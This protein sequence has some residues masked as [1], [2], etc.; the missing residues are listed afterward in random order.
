MCQLEIVPKVKA[1]MSTKGV[2]EKMEVITTI[3]HAD[4]KR[5]GELASIP[6]TD[7]AF[8]MSFEGSSGG[9]VSYVR[10]KDTT[11]NTTIGSTV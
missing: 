11:D 10:T 9:V 4:M 8:T 5:P 7:D 6:G 3:P 1:G 2:W